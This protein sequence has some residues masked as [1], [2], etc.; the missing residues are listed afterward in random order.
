MYTCWFHLVPVTEYTWFAHTEWIFASAPSMYVYSQ[1]AH[2][3]SLILNLQTGLV[4]PQYHCQYDDLFETTMGTQARSIPTSQWQFKAGLTSDKPETNEDKELDEELWEDQSFEE[5]YLTHES[6]EA[7]Q[8]WTQPTLTQSILKDLKLDGEE[9]KGR[10][11]KPN[12]ARLSKAP[13]QYQE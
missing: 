6:E 9:I 10:Q 8:E 2:S 12:V 1:H 5:Y 13:I 11:N 7:S 4:S 3:V